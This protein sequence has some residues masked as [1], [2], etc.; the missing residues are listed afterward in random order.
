MADDTGSDPTDGEDGEEAA[1]AS[2]A[3]APVEPAAGESVEPAGVEPAGV[4]PAAVEPA[5]VEPAA[6]QP[7]AEAVAPPA[8][9]PFRR[10]RLTRVISA[11]LI[12]LGSVLVPLSVLTVWAKA[13]ITDTD[14][15][16]ATLGPLATDPNIQAQISTSLSK[17]LSAA[18]DVNTRVKQILPPRLDP[19]AGP[20]DRAVDGFITSAVDKV[21]HS[22]S[23]G[24]IWDGALRTSHASAVRLLQGGGNGAVS[25]SQGKVTIDLHQLVVQVKQQL[26]AQGFT[27]VEHLPSGN[28]LGTVTLF[29]STALQ[30]TQWAFGALDKL[31][32]WLPVLTLLILAAGVLLSARP[33]RAVSRVGAY[34]VLGMAVM[35]VILQGARTAYLHHVPPQRISPAAAAA[36]Y[37]ILV[38]FLRQSCL[39]VLT[40]GLL[41]AVITFLAGPARPA[42][43]LR[44]GFT[45]LFGRIGAAGERSGILKLGLRVWVLRYRRW[46]WAADIVLIAVLIVF[47]DHSSGAAEIWWTVLGLAILALIEIVRA[48]TPEEMAAAVMATPLP[49]D[50]TPDQLPQGREP[51][52]VGAGGARSGNG[53]GAGDHAGAE[54]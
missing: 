13:T 48:R 29:Q 27:F 53:E 5:A 1:S 49:G 28:K 31:G 37:D 25:N 45:R 24:T 33:R 20:I 54:G 3:P 6:V 8:R 47:V 39:V 30:H 14:R 9:R 19:L 11:V 42:V 51:V 52:A 22:P 15:F 7:A 36:A 12:F 23:F 34:V 32:F 4:E 16:V 46:L 43:A 35:L 44:R 2:E 10:R 26:K 17:Q 50:G 18:A 21:V 40:L 41:V 38:R